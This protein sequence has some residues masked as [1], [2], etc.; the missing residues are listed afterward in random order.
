MVRLNANGKHI[1]RPPNVMEL[2][3]KW[4]AK[5]PPSSAG[6]VARKKPTAAPPPA[7][8]T[9]HWLYESSEVPIDIFSNWNTLFA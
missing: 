7:E 6:K 8:K 1:E 3:I 9:L 4:E 5:T 2:A